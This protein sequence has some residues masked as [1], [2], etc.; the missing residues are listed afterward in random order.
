MKHEGSVEG[1]CGGRKGSGTVVLNSDAR[2]RIQSRRLVIAP[3][4]LCTNRSRDWNCELR[5][6][7]KFSSAHRELLLC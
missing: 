4:I 6:D 1:V 2:L 7:H 3:L 5:E